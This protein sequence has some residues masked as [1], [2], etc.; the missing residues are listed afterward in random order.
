MIV[1][2]GSLYSQEYG[3]TL[4]QFLTQM[5]QGMSVEDCCDQLCQ[6]TLLKKPLM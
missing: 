1:L 3:I 6:P 2:E 4:M 5:L